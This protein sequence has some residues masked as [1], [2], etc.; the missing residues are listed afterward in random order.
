MV[1]LDTAGQEGFSAMRQHYMKDRDGFI[2]V[3]SVTDAASF[4]SIR[5]LYRQ[6]LIAQNR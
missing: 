4:H 3:Y 1:I 6:I 2:L 5:S